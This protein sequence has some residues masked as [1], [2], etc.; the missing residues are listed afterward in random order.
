MIRQV[1]RRLCHAP[2]VARGADTPTLAGEGDKVV[3]AAIVAAGAGKAM[4]E[5]AAFEVFAERLAHK[6]LW[7]VVVTL[8]VELAGAGQVK[9]GL[10]VFRYGLVEQRALGVARVVELGFAC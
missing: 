10:E 9:P 2:C 1:C 7:R 8:S 6:G 4:R 5:N 3:V